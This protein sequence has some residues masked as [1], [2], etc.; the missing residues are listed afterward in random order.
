MRRFSDTAPDKAAVFFK[1]YPG[2]LKGTA[3]RIITIAGFTKGLGGLLVNAGR[4]H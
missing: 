2:F 1:D 4:P 3:L